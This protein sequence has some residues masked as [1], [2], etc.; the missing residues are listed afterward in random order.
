MLKGALVGF[1]NVA[2]FGH[3][4]GYEASAAAEIVAVVEAAPERRAAAEK[5]NLSLGVFSSL[6]E[7]APD[8]IDFV[9][10]CTPPLFHAA[11]LA[12]A[13]ARGWHALCEKP[14]L[15]EPALLDEIRRAAVAKNVAVVPVHNWRYAPILR[16]ATERLR[17]GE[18][19][20][21]QRV[22]IVTRRK[23]AAAAADESD[24]RRDPRIA[25]G[26][27]LMDHGWHSLYL[28]LEW[29]GRLPEGIRAQ[30][31]RPNDKA[32][33]NAA[34]LELD[35]GGGTARIDLS[36]DADERS[37]EMKLIGERGE[38]RVADDRLIANG[39]STR[40]EPALS[41]G[42]HHADWFEAMLP[43][44]LAAFREPALARPKFE[45][46]ANCLTIIR[47]AYATAITL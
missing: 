14:L 13:I 1:G 33:E 28:T 23:R 11:P 4:P 10:I 3:S 20:E 24:W 40:F 43:D 2:Q 12:D 36:W 31:V 6:T 44:V 5:L 17:A 16:S 15:L 32:A 45:E 27:I 25:G 35:F 7:I 42:S 47:H 34:V 19:G 41:A 21:L 39:T 30:L 29:F 9:D 8:A 37:N 18:I 26:G 38:I 46:A 22:E